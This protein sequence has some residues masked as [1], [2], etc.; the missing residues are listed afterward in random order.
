MSGWRITEG[1]PDRLGLRC[2]ASG[3]DIAV[4]SETAERIELCLF[5]GL[6]ETARLTLP[7]R[8]GFI[9]HGRVEGLRP[10]KL[11]GLRAHGPWDPA[12]A[13]RFNPAK[14][15]LDPWATAL[16]GRPDWHDGQ[17]AHAPGAPLTPD[18]RDSAPHM[19]RCIAAPPPAPVDPAERPRRPWSETLI[20]EAHVR[21]LTRRH[22]DV[23]APLRGTYEALGHPAILDHL[24]GLGVTALE[25]QPIACFAD[26]PR[27]VALGLT[28]HW[29]Y[30][31]AALLAPE[32]RFMGPGGAAGLREA[33]R[34]LHARGIEVILDVV[35][36]HTAELEA[37]GPM[38]S[39]RGLC[40]AGYYRHAPEAP[41]RGEG[42]AYVNWS[43]CGNTL[44]LSNPMAQRLVL[45]ALRHW[46][47]GYGVDGFRFDLAP[48]LGRDGPDGAFDAGAGFLDALRQDPVLAP[49]KLIAE[50][51][52]LGPH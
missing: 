8:T 45:D 19:P 23:P 38:L 14:L 44:D 36:N 43:G 16:S 1:R 47:E 51:W 6:R 10:G 21:A 40:D 31:P 29:G 42:R 39:L 7:E 18:P 15:L 11:Y 27:L 35:A 3:A 22:P 50:P 37:E 17:R 5:D 25:L 2:D 33:I 34:A 48:V 20:Y 26:E 13:R 30:N 12:A 46:A 24:D 32:P 9:H 28:N 49:L 52:D 41:A 4:A